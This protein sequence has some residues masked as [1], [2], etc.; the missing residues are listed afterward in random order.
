MQ[1]YSVT[2][3]LVLRPHPHNA[4]MHPGGRPAKTQGPDIGQRIAAARRRADISQRELAQRLGVTQQTIAPLERRTS[5]PRGTTLVKVADIL[6]VSINELLGVKEDDR[7]NGMARG[8]AHQT[9]KAVSQLPRR[10]QSKILEVVD[11]LLAKQGSE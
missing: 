2:N 9:F 6:N 7:S 4:L 5:M 8:R 11:A 3:G 1:A 10:Q